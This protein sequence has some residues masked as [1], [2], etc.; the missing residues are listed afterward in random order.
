MQEAHLIALACGSPSAGHRCWSL[1]LPA[2]EM[3][4]L[5]FVDELSYVTIHH[6]MSENE[7]KPWLRKEWCIPPGSQAEFVY[8]MEAVLDVYQSRV[9][10]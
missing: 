5:E 6:I 4:R 2:Q 9:R 8:Y 3:V 1:R 7:I 10:F